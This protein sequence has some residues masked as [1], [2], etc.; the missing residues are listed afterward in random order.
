MSDAAARLRRGGIDVLTLCSPSAVRSVAGAVDSAPVVVCLG[1]T[2]AEAARACGLRVDGMA[3]STSM[4]SLVT[5]VEAALGTR[6]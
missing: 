6:V 2:T 4:A 3:A 5:A 1:E